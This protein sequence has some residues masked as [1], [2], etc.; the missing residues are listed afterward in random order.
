MKLRVDHEVTP[1]FFFMLTLPYSLKPLVEEEL[2]KL[3]NDGV[4][5][6]VQFSN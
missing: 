2:K 3:M 6:P 5:A 4:I 1:K